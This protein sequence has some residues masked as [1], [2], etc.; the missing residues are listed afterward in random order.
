MLIVGDERCCLTYINDPGHGV[1]KKN[2]KIQANCELV[3]G[4]MDNLFE[5]GRLFISRMM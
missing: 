4:D 3:G 1:V 2:K 5:N